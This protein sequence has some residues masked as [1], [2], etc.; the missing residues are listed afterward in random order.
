[1][2]NFKLTLNLLLLFSTV[3]FASCTPELPYVSTTKEVIVQGSWNV[4]YYFDGQDNT[5]QYYDFQFTFSNNG[6]LVCVKGADSFT[7]TWSMIKD[8]DHKDVLHISMDTQVTALT[9]LN[10]DWTVTTVNLMNIGMKSGN[11][12]QLVMAKL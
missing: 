4:Q 7:G 3:F 8:A 10:V 12:T 6:S 2:K 5:A 9:A 11:N 1:M